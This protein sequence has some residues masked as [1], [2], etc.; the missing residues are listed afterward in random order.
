[1]REYLSCL[2]NINKTHPLIARALPTVDR[3]R[4]DLIAQRPELIERIREVNETP[5]VNR[6]GDV[7]RHGF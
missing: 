2:R 3:C 5:V 1:M 6:H 4:R 7:M